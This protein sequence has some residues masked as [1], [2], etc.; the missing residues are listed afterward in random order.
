MYNSGFVILYRDEAE[1][2]LWEDPLQFHWWCF[3]RMKAASR[4]SLQTVGRT[5]IRVRIYYGEYATTIS[6]LSRIWDIDE[7]TVTSFLDLLEGDGRIEIRKENG[8]TIIK[9]VGYEKFSPPAGYFAKGV[10]RAKHNG[11]ADEM[12]FE[13]TS[14]LDDETAAQMPSEMLPEVCGQMPSEI[15]ADKINLEKDKLKNNSPSPKREAEFFEN[16]KKSEASLEQMAMSLRLPSVAAVLEELEIF[17]KYIM[18]D[19]KKFHQNYADFSS[20][21][22][23]WYNCCQTSNVSRN[24]KKHTDETKEEQT[25]KSRKSAS[26]RRGSEGSAR[27]PDDYDQP[28]PDF[29]G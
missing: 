23:R 10:K 15:P 12:P 18:A 14:E 25:R 17:E 9:I 20:H 2:W 8:I 3:L 24:S 13:M 6:Y 11:M 7:R 26:Q 16:L 21:F 4:P 5:R 19:P 1:D 27:T 28:F 29:P 22:I